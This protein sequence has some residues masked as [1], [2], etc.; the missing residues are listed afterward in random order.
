MICAEIAMRPTRSPRI[1]AIGASSTG[2]RATARPGSA[3]RKPLTQLTSGNRRMTCRNANATPISATRMMT[4][5]SPGLARNAAH[6][7]L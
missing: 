5:F 3:M 2:G 1:V 7:C 4:E 6:T